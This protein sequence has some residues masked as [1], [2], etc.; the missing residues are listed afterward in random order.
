MDAIPRISRAQKMD[1]LSSQAN[2][3]GYKAVLLCANALG[4]IFPMMI[5]WVRHLPMLRAA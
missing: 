5:F 1:A 2:L 4:K 3:A